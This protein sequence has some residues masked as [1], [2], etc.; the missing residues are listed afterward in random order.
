M[1]QGWISEE[2][3][4]PAVCVIQMGARHNYAYAQALEQR[5]ALSA[6]ITDAC[7]T[8]GSSVAGFLSRV[9]GARMG[10]AARR[11][12]VEGVAPAKVNCNPFVDCCR[13]LLSR[14]TTRESMYEI[15]DNLLGKCA[16]NQVP[17]GTN[18]IVNTFGNGGT[19]LEAAKARGI[20][21]ITDVIITPSVMETET[22]EQRAFPSW[23]SVEGDGRDREV[24]RSKIERINRVSD[25]LLCPSATV[26]TDLRKFESFDPAK[27]RILPYPLHRPVRGEAAPRPGRVLFA[28]AAGLRKG[29]HYLAEAAAILARSHPEIQ[30]VVAGSVSARIRYHPAAA[31]L[32]FLEHLDRER[33]NRETLRADLFCL[34][35]L[36]EGS[37]GAIMEAMSGGLPIV[38]TPASGSVVL[39]GCEGFIV[40]ERNGR[41]IAEAI[42]KIVEDRELRG[43]MSRKSRERA[44]EFDIH[45]WGDRLYEL[46]SEVV[47]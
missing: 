37:A 4:D 6:L 2:A 26:A 23:E 3:V 16:K 28:G 12:T 35:S 41:A 36:A 9:G 30:I 21:I 25:V 32:T 11:R 10:G 15:V 20:K 8:S 27:V 22:A 1:E 18:A 43:R 7:F 47:Q 40:P 14:V 13:A 31:A 39:D 33:M 42:V 45:S 46:V 44:A 34:P 24:W 17:A 5:E 29:I 38:T 19:L